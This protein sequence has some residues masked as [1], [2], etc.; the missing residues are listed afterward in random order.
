MCAA[1]DVTGVRLRVQT[2]ALRHLSGERSRIA[3]VTARL[4]NLAFAGVAGFTADRDLSIP[5]GSGQC[6]LTRERTTLI[7][8]TA[9]RRVDPPTFVVGDRAVS[10]V[11]M[12]PRDRGSDSGQAHSAGFRPSFD[13]RYLR[14]AASVDRRR[15][16]GLAAARR[17]EVPEGAIQGIPDPDREEPSPG[18]RQ[19]VGARREGEPTTED[20]A[21]TP[22]F[23]RT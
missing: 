19:V 23:E 6:D 1:G 10:P 4:V 3:L 7:P 12:G 2:A 17:S 15:R 20:T 22:T 21:S 5:Y 8:G 16:I 14:D 18:R 13:L 11:S 9:L